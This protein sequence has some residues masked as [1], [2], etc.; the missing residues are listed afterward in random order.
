MSENKGYYEDRRPAS[1]IDPYLVSAIMADTTILNSKYC[2][3][4]VGAY[5]EFK[6][7]R[8][9][10][11]IVFSKWFNIKRESINYSLYIILNNFFFFFVI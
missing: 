6:K 3:E 9:D 8:D 7:H 4:I 10:D 2:S 11:V 1:N 5:K